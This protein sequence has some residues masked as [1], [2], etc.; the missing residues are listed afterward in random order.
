MGERERQMKDQREQ[1]DREK[2]R[3]AMDLKNAFLRF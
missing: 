2:K 3:E 1:R